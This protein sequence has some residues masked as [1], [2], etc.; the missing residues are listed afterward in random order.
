MIK[1][2][3]VSNV[4]VGGI[5]GLLIAAI[6]LYY[7]LHPKDQYYWGSNKQIPNPVRRLFGVPAGLILLFLAVKDIIG[8]IR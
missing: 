4:G 2:A 3:S 1:S 6:F 5:V 7:G 8:G